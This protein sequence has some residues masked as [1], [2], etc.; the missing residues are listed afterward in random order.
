MPSVRW[1]IQSD[2]RARAGCEFER[3]VPPSQRAPGGRDRILTDI[4]SDAFATGIG[5][6]LPVYDG[7]VIRVFSVASRVRNRIRVSGNVW[8]PG[9]IGISPGMRLSDAL[10][11]AGGLRPNVY[12]GEVLITR[13]Q[14]D[15][16]RSA[17]AALRDIGGGV[18][19]DVGLQEDDDVRVFSISEF[20]PR[21]YVAING[22]VRKSGQ[23]PY[24]EGMT[25]RDLVLLLGGLE[26]SRI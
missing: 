4:T 26:Q 25:I 6:S 9:T 11:L 16:S 23:F 15:S 5:P 21:R 20:R 18:I 14:P 22:A 13:A 17:R 19:N 10:R 3:I 1:R 2:G 24:R 12:L 8:S 7:D